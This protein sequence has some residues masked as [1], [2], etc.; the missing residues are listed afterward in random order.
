MRPA[1]YIHQRGA[2]IDD[3]IERCSDREDAPVEYHRGRKA[4]IDWVRSADEG[5]KSNDEIRAKAEEKRREQNEKRREEAWEEHD[6]AHGMYEA[7][8]W[9]LGVDEVN[10]TDS[11][12]AEYVIGDEAFVPA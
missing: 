6:H 7:L 5:F 8:C 11:G 12:D 3:E 9:V 4:A 2:E 10:M 1:P